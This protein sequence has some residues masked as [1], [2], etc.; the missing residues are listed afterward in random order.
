M[1]ALSRSQGSY[2]WKSITKIVVASRDGFRFHVDIGHVYFQYNKWITQGFLYEMVPFV[3][4][5]DTQMMIS[6]V[7]HDGIWQLGKLAT[8]LR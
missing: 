6:D 8:M 2:T 4:I 5:Q 1:C 7:F 3:N